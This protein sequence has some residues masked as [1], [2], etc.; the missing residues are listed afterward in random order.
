MA[1]AKKLQHPYTPQLLTNGDSPKQLL[2]RSRYL[3][4]KHKDIWTSSQKQRA[5][6]IFERYPLIKRAWYKGKAMK[7]FVVRFGTHVCH[8]YSVAPKISSK[9][10]TVSPVTDWHRTTKYLLK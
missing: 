6:L 3:L 5:R 2:A 1:T 4:F 8:L 10:L 7:Q 9:F